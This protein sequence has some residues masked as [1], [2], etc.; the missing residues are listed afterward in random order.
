VTLIGDVVGSRSHHDRAALQHSLSETLRF[1]NE[2]L[3]PAQP[4]EL[5]V[6]DEFQGG[7]ADVAGA[8]R[9]SL[10]VRLSLLVGADGIDSRYGLGEGEVT[11]FDSNRAPL[12][13]DGPGWWSARAAI[14]R[15]KALAAAPR[16]AFTRTC[17]GFGPENPDTPPSDA[18]V[19]AFLFCRDAIVERMSMR[20]RGQ[21]LGLMLGRSQRDLAAEEHITQ[22]AVSQ[23]LHRSGAFAVEIAQERLQ[24]ASG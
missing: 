6:G 8:A 18:A 14:D 19:E 1:A 17:L 7:F 24:A 20:Q 13:Q 23:S 9:A 21:L 11:V 15:A 2:T 5:A 10:V 12:S 4:L 22:G 16:T 3:K